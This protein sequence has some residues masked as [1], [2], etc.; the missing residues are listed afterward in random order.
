MSV[1]M[2]KTTASVVMT[3]RNVSATIIDCLRAILN[4]TFQEFEIIII[5]DYSEDCTNAEIKKLND[6]RIRYFRNENWLGISPSRNRGI[7]KAL[8]ENVFFTDGDCQVSKNWIEVGLKSLNK[9][10]CVGVEGRIYYVS[11]DYKPTF[12]DHVME[13]KYGGNFMTG[14]IAY[15]KAVI[16]KVGGFDEKLTYLE[17]RDIAFRIMKYGKI[18]FNPE[19]VVYHPQVKMTPKMLVESASNI[20]NKVHLYKKLRRKELLLWRIVYPTN[21]IRLLCPP[22][23]F[24]SLISK[25]FKTSED[26]RLLPFIYIFLL[27]QRLHL[28]KESAKE[29][30]FLI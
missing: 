28:W 5:D 29:R 1:K 14:N 22:L 27:F 26:F 10:N 15:K 12:S 30:V 8:G 21:L 2:I 24:S 20:K 4:Q 6:A 3:V 11:D 17:D 23:I 7:K 13:N 9:P 25:R 18:C 19:M 16:E